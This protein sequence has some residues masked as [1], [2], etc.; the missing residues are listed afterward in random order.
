MSANL[1]YMITLDAETRGLQRGASEWRNF[2]GSIRAGVGIDIGGRLVSGIQGLQG[3]L[4][5]AAM[6][7]VDFRSK[8]EDLAVSFRTLLGSSDA[9]NMRIAELAKFA[10]ETPFELPGIGKANKVLETLT[11]G[12]LS[13]KDG[14]KLVGDA[15]AVADAPI[16][17]LAVHIGRLYDALMSGRKAGESI[18]RLQEL[19]IISGDT[20]NKIES[21]QKVGAKGPE[22]WAVASAALGR[23]AGEM[24]RRSQTFSGRLS[25]LRDTWNAAMGEMM[26]GA[27]GASGTGFENLTK[28]LE[29]PET[30]QALR[31]MGV[32]IRSVVEDLAKLAEWAV[33]HGPQIANTIATVGK[34][35][36]A[37]KI[38]G[39]VGG[40]LQAA[41]GATLAAGGAAG[42]TRGVGGGAAAAG[43]ASVGGV[44]S[45]IG[46][47]LAIGTVVQDLMAQ[48]SAKVQVEGDAQKEAIQNEKTKVDEIR[49]QMGLLE[50]LAAKK[51]LLLR[52][53]ED[54]AAA[55]TV[56]DAGLAAKL[57]RMR[58]EVARVDDATL[59][60]R[61]KAATEKKAKEQAELNAMENRKALDKMNVEIAQDKSGFM[62]K[63]QGADRPEQIGMAKQYIADLQA[64]QQRLNPANSMGDDPEEFKEKAAR[65]K[66]LYSEITS[67]QQRLINLQKGE[68]RERDQA[69]KATVRDLRGQSYRDLLSGVSADERVGLLSS[70][71]QQMIGGA[72]GNGKGPDA[73]TLEKIRAGIDKLVEINSQ[74]DDPSGYWA[75]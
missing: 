2:L 44:I 35:F 22:V 66:Q 60:A 74:K 9:A 70:R 50:S 53:D 34:A 4:R 37:Y 17:E 52:I 40:G 59:T 12:A 56:G 18:M 61:E 36:A 27:V 25:T 10:A 47:G 29:R 62:E 72:G 5:G 54:I 23:F 69:R 65:Y 38:A 30:I 46:V 71:A 45:A 57:G 11:K 68:D 24:E 7:G 39:I 19:G 6:A 13:G 43:A 1:Q 58:Q 55:Q 15:A 16:E 20:R 51:Q 67:W 49:R 48:Y 42:A 73:A 64:E 14:M 41:A 63:F 21:L 3:A 8:I 33:K 26:A 31:E 32:R 75:D 28:A